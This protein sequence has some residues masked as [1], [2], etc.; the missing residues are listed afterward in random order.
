MEKIIKAIYDAIDEVNEQLSKE[1]RLSKELNTVLFGNLDSLGLMNFIVVVEQNIE[2][3]F[4]VT[5]NLS[6]EK[7]ISQEQNP[8]ADVQTLIDYITSLLEG[9][10]ND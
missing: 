1:Q 4:G 5:I 10:N 3:L 7:T 8:L 9:G 6:D 2:K